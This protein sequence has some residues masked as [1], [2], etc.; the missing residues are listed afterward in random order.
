MIHALS[1]AT[2][3]LAAAPAGVPNPGT[4]EAPPGADAFLTIIKW[5]AFIVLGICVLGVIFAGG[6]MAFGG[7]HGEGSEHASRLG[8]V[9]AGSIVVGSASGIVAALL[10]AAA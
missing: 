6:R 7:R 2:D 8:W 1:L 9:L 5:A 4:G 3:V 10:P